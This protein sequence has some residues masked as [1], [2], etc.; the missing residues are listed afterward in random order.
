MAA[1]LE[2]QGPS[3]KCRLRRSFV[4][5]EPSVAAH[6]LLLVVVSFMYS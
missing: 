4:H 6:A 5:S 3:P 1:R 2:M